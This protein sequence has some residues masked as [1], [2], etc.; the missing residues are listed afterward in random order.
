LHWWWLI[1]LLVVVAVVWLQ[2]Y[3]ATEA[4]RLRIDEWKLRLPVIGP[5]LCKSAFAQFART[6]AALLRNGVPVL[7]ALRIVADIIQNKVISR[8]LL[9]ARER[10]TDGTTISSPLA[11]GKIFPPLL[12]D[13]LAVGEE[14]GD[15]VN[16]LDQ[17]ADTYENELRRGIKLFLALLEPGIIIF[18][19]LTVGLFVFSIFIAI[20]KMSPGG[21]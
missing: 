12:L 3:N 15:M 7:D 13:M 2:R 20:F 6:L 14:T 4:G 17:I 8:E 5:I 21:R 10:V 1:A 11:E 18:L 16:A 9:Q 19:A